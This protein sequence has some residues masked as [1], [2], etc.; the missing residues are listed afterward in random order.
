MAETHRCRDI[1]ELAGLLESLGPQ[2]AVCYGQMPYDRARIV[3]KKAVEQFDPANTDPPTIARSRDYFTF[4]GT[5]G[6]MI[7]HD[8]DQSADELLDGMR[9]ILP[10]IDNAPYLVRPSASS[11]IYNKITGEQLRGQSGLR[12]IMTVKDGRD[13]QRAAEILDGRAWLAGYGTIQVTTVGH[14]IARNRLFD[15]TVF[16]PERLDFCGGA[17]CSEPLEQRLS[18]I[19]ISNHAVPLN[20]QAVLPDLTNTEKQKIT[21]LKTE[22]KKQA[23][24]RAEEVQNT[25]VDERVEEEINQLPDLSEEKEKELIEKL[26]ERYTAA[27]KHSRL[28]GDFEITLENGST[29]T[30]GDI[31][32]DPDKYH[33]MRCADPLEPGYRGDRRISWIN[34][35][36]AGRP[37]I[38]SHAHGG[39]KFTL[40]RARKT[41]N[42]MGGE[43]YQ[44]V[45]Q[46][47]ELLKIEGQIYE[48]GDELVEVGESARIMPLT[49]DGVVLAVD[50]VVGFQKFNKKVGDWERVDCP[51][52]IG[53]GLMAARNL[54]P[55]PPLRNTATAPA[56]DPKTDRVIDVEGYDV[57]TGLMIVLGNNLRAWP[58]VPIQPT[59]DQCRTALEQLML[60]FRDFPFK[61]LFDRSVILTAL[62]TASV[63]S[64]LPTA[65]GFAVNAPT[66][67]SGKTLL[68]QSI[69]AIA[70]SNTP[71]VIPV[72]DQPEEIRKVLLSFGRTGTPVLLFD[73]IVG[74]FDSPA[75]C[76]FLTSPFFS[77]RI[78]G[79]SQ[80][81][82]I[83]TS[84]LMLFTGN[85][86]HLKG[87]LC[88]RVLRC[89]IDPQ[90]ES[91]WKRS[92]PLHPGEYC[93]ENRYALLAAA[94]T[95]LRAARLAGTK[96]PN[97]TASFETWSDIVR[98]T[99]I[100][101]SV[102][103]L[104]A[105]PDPIDC[106]DGAFH[107]DPETTRLSALLN[108]WYERYSTEAKTVSQVIND[109]SECQT[110]L[111]ECLEDIAGERGLVNARRLGA[112]LAKY[113]G[114]IV[115]GLRI[116]DTKKDLC[117]AKR[118]RVEPVDA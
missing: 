76:G 89:N 105:L 66:A 44:H 85:N 7:D 35:R 42:L 109:N 111:R 114:R 84:Q 58:G 21:D 1:N 13:I 117:R 83:P 99:I 75:L 95:L 56:Y 45:Q 10:E 51:M 116:V 60:P 102:S 78:L 30:V 36:S 2:N 37:N 57:G 90:M 61:G 67:G 34:L 74:Y 80:F 91:P 43:R 3:T 103:G 46:V 22:A 40:I 18:T 98:G 8:G 73:N 31:L 113:Q 69:S 118:W 112:W 64:F 52:H 11:N 110:E 77:D 63:R 16:Q 59:M 29:V 71:A 107:D 5:S 79:K 27:V 41:I 25:Y 81:L 54:W 104:W 47:L 33:N 32:D 88:R 20:T 82:E 24:P 53:K 92:F 26:R 93:R 115:D 86:L 17:K 23:R 101:V 87:D 6:M 38:Y 65:P 48:R 96:C 100:W 94:Y 108:A 62:L 106:L 50:R 55:F 70:G 12:L 14:M 72:S 15:T 49:V 19:K 28:Y 9:S 4:K 68:A 97:R 39:R